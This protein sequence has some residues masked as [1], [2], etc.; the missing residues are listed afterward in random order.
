MERWQEKVKV[1]IALIAVVV[2]VGATF[3][4]IM[5]N[6][7]NDRAY[8][9]HNL[10]LGYVPNIHS[11][12][13]GIKGASSNEPY[14]P[15]TLTHFVIIYRE[16]HVFD[17]YLGDLAS[18]MPNTWESANNAAY[19][20]AN[21]VVESTNHIADVPYLHM[22]A[23]NY[24]VFDNYYSGTPPASGPNHWY[25]FAAAI[26]GYTS[27]GGYTGT[28]GSGDL[29][30]A[31]INGEPGNY[32]STGT[33]F[34]RF[35]ANTI[36]WVEAGD[37]YWILNKGQA[38]TAASMPSSGNGVGW[39]PVDR[40]GTNIPQEIDYS[41][42]TNNSQTTPDEVVAG[43]YINYVNTYGM[44]VWNYIE[45]FNDHQGQTDT[46]TGA[47]YPAT[48][49]INDAQTHRIVSYIEHSQYA[50]NTVIIVTEDDTSGG[51]NGPDHVSNSYRVP[52]VV[53]APASVEKHH[54]LVQE[55]Y[56]TT[57]VIAVAER[58]IAN[59]Y[60]SALNT[61]AIGTGQAGGGLS[62][63]PMN[64]NDSYALENPLEAIW[65]QSS[66]STLTAS[67]NSNT[68]GGSTP[69]LVNF[70]GIASGGTAPYSYA[71]NFGDGGSGNGGVI[72][73][74]FNTAGSY[75]VILTVTD[76]NGNSA[77]SS[78]V[79][80]AKSPTSPLT[81]SVSANA[82][83]GTAPMEVTFTATASGGTAPY[84]YAWNFGD[85]GSGNG[86]S[87]SHTYTKAGN[88]TSEVSVT[89]ASTQTTTGTVLITVTGNSSIA[90]L[91]ATASSNV[92][93]GNVTL[94]VQFNGNAGGGISPYT[95]QWTF[96]DGATSTA[97][98]P[99][100]SY[101]ISGT[102]TVNLKV[103]D[104]NGDHATSSVTIVAR[105][106]SSSA[107]LVAGISATPSTGTAPL[108]VSFSGSVSGGTTPYSY[109][110]NFGDG[111]T[112]TGQTISHV[113][114][115]SGT[116]TATLTVTD[117][118]GTT[119]TSTA[120]ISAS[121]V[122]NNG[123]LT[124][125]NVTINTS[126][127][128]LMVNWNSNDA[129]TS[130]IEVGSSSGNYNY[131][132]FQGTDSSSGLSHSITIGGAAPGVTYY[133]R[134]SATA[135]SNTVWSSELNVVTNTPT[136]MPANGHKVSGTLYYTNDGA[137]FVVNVSSNAYNTY[138]YITI[139][140]T[141]G[142]VQGNSGSGG[143]FNLYEGYGYLP[144]TS[145]YDNYATGPNA[146]IQVNLSGSGSY[147]V[148]VYAT[149]GYGTFTIQAYY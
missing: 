82:T 104:S 139:K 95:W 34:D 17:D 116:Y 11:I 40:P 31:K 35:S 85:G 79:I 81:V 142:T 132:T 46:L 49:A 106:V 86:Q 47:T 131:G 2:M 91:T 16:N 112:G 14:F 74:T 136:N 73:H 71:W 4:L 62:L 60:P 42:Y 143:P 1:L 55:N 38:F 127:T 80:T 18:P 33:V 129:A 145:S 126:T 28:P 25:L 5:S 27:T 3:A 68:T 78:L 41:N 45:L 76:S 110:W 87:V 50:N 120:Q 111:N 115:S 124:I 90:P 72:A 105:S 92:T 103:T 23:W 96:G 64:A 93:S 58:V 130:S 21:A 67:I 22:L 43:N 135:G 134:V 148:Y 102:Y 59:V 119:A 98:N 88:Y 128:D 54:L 24:T 75:T 138:N 30:S 12:K 149:D 137:F 83:G 125:S 146:I 141:D 63:F 32:P 65:K 70:T 10:V 9:N 39:M 89:D 57:N 44:P 117:N 37:I 84:S 36:P 20:N 61:A 56:N 100:H 51:S 97:Q 53:I 101:P 109:A 140:E 108:T 133:F 48:I 94:F 123:A 69:L 26:S 29:N 66:T 77:T 6:S 99:V 144:S 8:M 52:M 113:Y 7:L 118:S 19:P 114:N 122:P 15:S 107:P 13:N 121:S 147:Y